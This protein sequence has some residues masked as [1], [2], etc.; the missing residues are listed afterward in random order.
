MA[1]LNDKSIRELIDSGIKI[2]DPFTEDNLQPASIDLRL[3]N[4]S[5]EYHLK[6][7]TLGD[8]ID[9]EEDIIKKN[10]ESKTIKNG[11]SCFVGIYEKLYI[12][13]N[14]IGLIMPRSSISRLGI[15]IVPTYMN[16]GYNGHMPLT[17][18]NHTGIDVV[19]KPMLRVVQLILFP[20][21]GMPDKIYSK[22]DGAKYHDDDVNPSM[23]HTDKELHTIMDKILQKETP[24]LYK[25]I[26]SNG[27]H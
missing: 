8:S 21:S 16:P 23:L 17:I 7:Y 20:L 11:E 22:S 27:K 2:V 5:Y 9:E 15:H 26:K 24:I 3:G 12:P 6:Q 14:V 4:I 25:M 1:A 18:I 13:K 19:I 10:F